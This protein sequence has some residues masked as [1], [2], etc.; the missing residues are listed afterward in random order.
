MPSLGTGQ[1]LRPR[2]VLERDIS[3]LCLSFLIPEI[4]GAPS[5]QNAADLGRRLEP[6]DRDRAHAPGW[7]HPSSPLLHHS[8]AV[9]KLRK[10]LPTS[11]CRMSKALRKWSE[12]LPGEY[13]FWKEKGKGKGGIGSSERVEG[14][15]WASLL[16]P[17]P[18][19]CNPHPTI[20]EHIS[21]LE[22]ELNA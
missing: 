16:G 13:R 10:P 21:M 15:V 9:T 17:A 14:Q 1:L 7:L 19:T 22:S 2:N 6:L 18:R 11:L 5:K 3:V 4:S 12:K 20:H 8:R